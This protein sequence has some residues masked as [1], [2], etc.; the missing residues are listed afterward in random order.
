MVV[1]QEAIAARI[2]VDILQQGGNAVDAA[3]A[4]GFALAVT[5]PRAGNL[6]GGGFMLIHRVTATIPRSIIARPRRRR[7]PTRPFSIRMATPIRK[8]RAIPR[9]PSACR[10]RSPVSRSPSEKYGSGHFTLADLIAPAIALARD[11]M[12][13]DRGH[14]RICRPT[15]WRGSRAGRRR[16]KSFS[17]PTAR[18]LAP[19]D[20]LVQ[21]DLANTLEA[22]AKDGPH[23]FY[24]GPIADKIAA[25]VQAAGGVMTVDDLKG[26]RRIRAHAGARHLSRLRHRLHAAAVIGRRRADRDAQHPRRLRSRPARRRRKRCISWSRR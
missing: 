4:V 19:G 26:Y 17:N 2:G 8:N 16:Q 14:S 10:A 9:S 6:G 25:A 24:D 11:G 7:S 13:V 3:V 22:I 1:A 5:Y 18:A 12:P 15:S 23:A 20:R 21:S